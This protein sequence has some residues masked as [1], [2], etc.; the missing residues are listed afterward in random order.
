M[1]G[2]RRRPSYRSTSLPRHATATTYRRKVFFLFFLLTSPNIPTKGGGHR[3]RT[4]KE[5][6][7]KVVAAVL[8]TKLIQFLAAVAIFNQDDLKNGGMDALKKCMIIR[9]TPDQTTTLSKWMFSQ[10]LL[11]KSS[12][13]LYG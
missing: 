8:G 3:R 12:L 13:W 10:K 4:K 1:T 7:A 6:K 2:R 9:F 5:G 11:F